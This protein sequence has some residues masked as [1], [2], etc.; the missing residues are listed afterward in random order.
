MRVWIGFFALAA[1]GFFLSGCA[2][3]NHMAE[4]RN[5]E[6][7]AQCQSYG[8][9]PGTDAY[10]QCRMNLSNQREANQRA[11]V[12]A[13]LANQPQPYVLPMPTPI[14][15]LPAPRTCTSSVNGQMIY[16]NCN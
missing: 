6:D 10:F 4:M 13:Y 3:E 5:Q 11:I 12:G 14:Q 8:A 7:M 9:Q 1:F 15:P 2:L 16:T